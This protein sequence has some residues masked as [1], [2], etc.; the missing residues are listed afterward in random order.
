M[1]IL[2]EFNSTEE[3]SRKKA[4]RIKF[5]AQN[6]SKQAVRCWEEIHE[7]FYM[8]KDCD[9]ILDFLGEDA[10]SVIEFNEQLFAFIHESLSG[11]QQSLVDRLLLKRV[12]EPDFEVSEEGNVSKSP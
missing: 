10:S 6:F 11:K 7:T 1:S 2:N 5:L 4:E 12:E 8:S 9:H 3:Q